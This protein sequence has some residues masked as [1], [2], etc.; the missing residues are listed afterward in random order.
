MHSMQVQH[1]VMVLQIRFQMASRTLEKVV[2]TSLVQV[3]MTFQTCLTMQDRQQQT[4]EGQQMQ[5]EGQQIQS[6]QQKKT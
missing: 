1:G 6:A 2:E 4:L 5:Q 3:D